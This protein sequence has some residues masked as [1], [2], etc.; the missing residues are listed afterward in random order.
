M[1]RILLDG[2]I[3][4]KLAADTVA[5]E[6]LRQRVARTEV[7]II[8]TPVLAAELSESP[9][10]GFPNWFPIRVQHDCVAIAGITRSGTARSS[11]GQMY[12]AHRGESRGNGRD[13]IIAQAANSM[14]D[15]FVSEDG[16]SRRR[17]ARLS[18]KCRALS[19]EEF[20]NW[21]RA[22]AE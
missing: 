8:A 1:V 17:L 10:R 15:I 19:F 22:P 3:Y 11:I 21:F 20:S 18:Q 7:T 16:R 6:L 13:A 9:F 5:R 4:G 14:A 12:R 2:N